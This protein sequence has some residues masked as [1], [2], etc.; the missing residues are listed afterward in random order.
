MASAHALFSWC[1]LT[2]TVASEVR[3]NAWRV[4]AGGALCFA[5]HVA[6]QPA[7]RLESPGRQAQQQLQAALFKE[8][9][10]TMLLRSASIKQDASFIVVSDKTVSSPALESQFERPS[11]NAATIPW[12]EGPAPPCAPR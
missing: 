5:L 12:A 10:E 4:G 7:E 8:T 1:T 6:L 11:G 9:Q 2:A 3:S